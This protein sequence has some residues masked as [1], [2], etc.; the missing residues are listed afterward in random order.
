MERTYPF[1]DMV[2]L[3]ILTNGEEEVERWIDELV[4][5]RFDA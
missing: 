3:F 5:I 4:D 1:K 2:H